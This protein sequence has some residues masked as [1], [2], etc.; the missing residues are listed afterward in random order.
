[1]TMSDGLA[2]LLAWYRAQGA[3]PEQLLEREVVHN[4]AR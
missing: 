4:W 1:M 3:T 2:A